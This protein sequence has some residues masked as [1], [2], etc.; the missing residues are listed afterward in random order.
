MPHVP[1]DA[2]ILVRYAPE[3]C[4]RLWLKPEHRQVV[5]TMPAALLAGLTVEQVAEQ[6]FI[7]TNSPCELDGSTLAGHIRNFFAEC[8]ERGVWYLTL[9]VGDSVEVRVRDQ[10]RG[11]V[12]IEPVG[13]SPLG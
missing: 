5:I 8:T 13:F 7:A 12:R 1:T 3:R 10:L 4:E 2:A 9:S 11:G 6:V